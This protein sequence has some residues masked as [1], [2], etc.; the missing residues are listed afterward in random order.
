MTN[1]RQFL[2]LHSGCSKIVC[3]QCSTLLI[4]RNTKIKFNL[5]SLSKM[6]S[7]VTSNFFL[8][9]TDEV[10]LRNVLWTW[11]HKKVKTQTRVSRFGNHQYGAAPEE[12]N[13]KM[14]Q[15]WTENKTMKNFTF[16]F[17]ETMQQ[18]GIP[19]CFTGFKLPYT[20]VKLCT[21][22]LKHPI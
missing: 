22:D 9:Q 2:P 5:S 20:L 4:C 3:W 7:V 11:P 12:I 16:L 8:K 10:N 15:R 1:V 14:I 18:N 13:S 19:R 17:L 6:I 21:Q